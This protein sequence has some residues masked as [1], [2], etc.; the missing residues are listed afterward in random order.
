MKNFFLITAIATLTACGGSDKPEGG[1]TKDL[2]L[3]QGKNGEIINSA[4]GTFLNHYY[5]LKD[6]LVLS[7]DTMA[8]TAARLLIANADSLK[9][10][11]LKADSSIVEMA[12]GY[13]QSISAEAKALVAEAGI[14]AKRKS[15]QM[16]SDNMY[17][18]VR[19]VRFDQQV[20]YHQFC[21]MANNDAGA[22]WL[23]NTSEIK[24]PYFGKKM[25]TCGEVRDS[26]D[27]RGR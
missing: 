11:E 8:A 20:V 27:F 13:V 2:P 4:F 9:V 6:A 1:T 23:S 17:D 19:S 15:F 5:Q 7:N 10:N 24:N 14:E 22:Y 16:I 3:S 12:E 26:L 18:L 21:P 25:L